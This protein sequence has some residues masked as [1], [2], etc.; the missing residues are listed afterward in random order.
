MEDDGDTAARMAPTY[1]YFGLGGWDGN[2]KAIAEYVTGRN[3]ATVRMSAAFFLQYG[4]DEG[5]RM[6]GAVGLV[7]YLSGFGEPSDVARVRDSG[8][9]GYILKEAEG[10]MIIAS[11]RRIAAELGI[12]EKSVRNGIT[13]VFRKLHV[14]NRFA[15]LGDWTGWLGLAGMIFFAFGSKY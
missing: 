10:Q 14:S 6:Q 8:A 13:T 12:A 9:E 11:V 15:R 3:G 7:I 5:G 4:A 1:G 2:Y